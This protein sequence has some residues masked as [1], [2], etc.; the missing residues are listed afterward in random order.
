MVLVLPW[1]DGVV[2]SMT[3][4]SR[5][6]LSDATA[7]AAR[8]PPQYDVIVVGGG[9]AGSAAA[10]HCARAGLR[11]LL[12]ERHAFAEAGASWVNGIYGG[13][14]DEAG[15]ARP[16]APELRAAGHRF[17]LVAGWT[18]RPVT[19]EDGGVIDVDMRLLNARLRAGAAAA[20]AELRDG[21]RVQAIRPGEVVT[22]EVLHARL[23]V[24]ATGLGGL[25]DK[26][27]PHPH[28]VCTAAQ[29][30]YAVHDA[31]A[32]RA[33]FEGFGAAVGET[34]CFAAVAGGYSIVATRLEEVAG[35]LELSV[36]TGSLAAFGHTAGRPL[37]DAFV[38]KPWVG[39]LRFGGHAPIPLHR[40]HRRLAFVHGEHAVVRLGDAAGQV[41]AAHGSGVGA[42]LVAARMLATAF[43]EHGVRGATRFE[44]QWH[45]RFGPVFFAADAFRRMSKL[46]GP[47][48]LDFMLR[49][50]LVPKA[51]IRA[52][53]TAGL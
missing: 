18:G 52:G 28:D 2:Q 20:G 13:A 5:V 11:T 30:I 32:A 44:R 33:Y 40:P 19:I 25:F 46:L 8:L 34:V 38:D 27:K 15:I 39:P 6:S 3:Y 41:F 37:R 47:R 50:G 29:G 4:E 51:L 23:V 14:F 24:D 43:A 22:D 9:S 31:A 36:L 48:S 21:V 35:E 12:L 49:T 10:F 16:E 26:R 7:E 17:H 53:F 45:R 1:V 42:Q